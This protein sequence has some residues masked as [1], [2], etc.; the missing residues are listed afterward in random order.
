MTIIS[1]S[2]SHNKAKSVVNYDKPTLPALYLDRTNTSS[3]A[4]AAMTQANP[5]PSLPNE[6]LS[7]CLLE[8]ADWGD[9]AKLACVQSSW[10]SIVE[11]A[12]STS[13]ESKWQ[14]GQAL[15]NGECGLEA[16]SAQA[17]RHFRELSCVRMDETSYEYAAV[18]AKDNEQQ[19]QPHAPSM[20][21]LAE[22]E[23]DQQ[24]TATMNNVETGMSNNAIPQQSQNDGD[25]ES[26]TAPQP[27]RT[28][29]H[30]AKLGMAWLQAA[31]EI[32]DD[33][34][35]AY[36]LALNYE[37]GKHQVVVDVVAAFE[38]FQKAANAGHI[39]AMAELGLCYEL[40]CGV[41]QDDQLALDWYTK[42]A[43]E[44]HV[45]AKFSVAEAFEEARGVPQS[46]E[47][48]CLWYYR[49]AMV[50]DEDSKLALKRLYDIARIVVPGVTSLLN[51]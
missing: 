27:T 18:S 9:L 14:L 42:A 19:Q 4:A 33:A 31:Y 11:D 35:A 30:H 13:I 50:G 26:A 1:T 20:R 8:Y 17:M 45:T 3:T 38:W 23:F 21:K 37:Y 6:L 34:D 12:A 51:V 5:A 44:G 39:D 43:N 2:A 25:S 46:D 47:E 24:L 41:E 29:P 32:G 40:G 7:Q 16:N 36:E 49:A 15:Q 48:A 10:K 28:T 22:F